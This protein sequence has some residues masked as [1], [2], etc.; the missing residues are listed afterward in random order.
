MVTEGSSHG[1]FS[2]TV[3]ERPDD[4]S[5]VEYWMLS[6]EDVRVDVDLRCSRCFYLN[7]QSIRENRT[8]MG[9]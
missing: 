4:L 3:D 2:G 7:T 8:R 9:M 5:I 6:W 1:R